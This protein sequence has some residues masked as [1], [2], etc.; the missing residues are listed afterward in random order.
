MAED[1]ELPLDPVIEAFKSGVDRSLIEA[2]LRRSI[3]ERIQRM[4]AA[5]KLAEALREAGR[6]QRSS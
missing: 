6:K 4:I 3:D 1:P 2:Q 5:L